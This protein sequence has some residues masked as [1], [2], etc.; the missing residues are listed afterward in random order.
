MTEI[1]IPPADGNLSKARDARCAP[2][3]RKA[4]A[5]CLESKVTLEVNPEAKEIKD[6]TE[7]II[8]EMALVDSTVSDINWTK[9]LMVQ[10]IAN[11][12]LATYDAEAFESGNERY[13]GA[14]F[15]ILEIM[16]SENIELGM[17]SQEEVQVA[18]KSVG[19]KIVAKL[20]ELGLNAVEVEH[21]FELL[22]AM[23]NNIGENVRANVEFAKEKAAEKLF[24]VDSLNNVRISDIVRV[25]KQ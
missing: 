3:A 21:V 19:P 23:A 9:V 8:A 18:Y 22:T 10:G 16:M 12:M 11:S 1:Q 7:K 6:V 25:Q 24:G 17:L 5:L 14:A 20:K 13:Y 2:V 15:A 4:L